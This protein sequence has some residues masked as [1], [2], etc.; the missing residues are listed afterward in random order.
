MTYGY[1]SFAS[2]VGGMDMTY[3]YA[4]PYQQVQA[5]VQAQAQAQHAIAM[6]KMGY[7]AFP[8]PYDPQGNMLQ[9]RVP[10]QMWN[11]TSPYGIPVDPHSVPVLPLPQPFAPFH[12]HLPLAFTVHLCAFQFRIWF[13]W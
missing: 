13:R 3:A 7:S 1:A 10:P 11:G 2:Y 8:T 12:P 6:A 4:N 9:P 5:Q